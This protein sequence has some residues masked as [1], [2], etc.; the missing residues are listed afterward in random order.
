MASRKNNVKRN[1][2]SKTNTNTVMY[3]ILG[4]FVVIVLAAL[5]LKSENWKPG[6]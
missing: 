4:L 2:K 5:L 3:V 1:T 6:N